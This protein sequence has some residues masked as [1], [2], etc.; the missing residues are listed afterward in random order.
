VNDERRH[1]ACLAVCKRGE[2]QFGVLQPAVAFGD[3][4]LLRTFLLGLLLISSAVDSRAVS[5]KAAAG[6]PQSRFLDV[7]KLSVFGRE[8]LNPYKVEKFNKKSLGPCPD[9]IDFDIGVEAVVDG[10]SVDG[11]F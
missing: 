11:C 8:R 7:K 1:Y 5:R 4:A 10:A 9:D 6:L 2:I 3:A